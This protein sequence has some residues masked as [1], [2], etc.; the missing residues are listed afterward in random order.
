MKRKI[1]MLIAILGMALTMNAQVSAKDDQNNCKLV[2]QIWEEGGYDTVMKAVPADY[3]TSVFTIKLT[4]RYTPELHEIVI[5]SFDTNPDLTIGLRE[6]GY[7]SV[8]LLYPEPQGFRIVT[9]M[10]YL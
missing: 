2:N 7:K 9:K 3:E 10:Y 1:L 4:P 8:R 6:L 5:E